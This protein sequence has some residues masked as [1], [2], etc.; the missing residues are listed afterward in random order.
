[1]AYLFE[2]LTVRG[3][4]LRNRLGVSPM[5]QYSSVDGLANEW[6]FVHLGARAVGG[7]ALVHVEATAVSPEGRISLRD[8]GLWSDAHVEP[9]ARIARFVSSQGAVAAIQLAHAGRKAS[10]HPP[11]TATEGRA[12]HPAHGGVAAAASD[13]GVSDAD[14]GWT[15]VAP[16]A[17]PFDEGYRQ[18]R[19]LTVE[20]IGAVVRQFRDAAERARAAGF[21]WLELHAA[22]GYLLH[23]FLSPLANKRND[24][25]GGSFDDRVRIVIDIVRAVRR[26]WPERLPLAVRLSCSDWRDDGWTLED[27][28]ALARRLGAE[29]VDLIDCSSGGILPR[30][31]IPVG[32]GYQVPFAERIRAQAGIMTA[33]VGMIT[34]SAQCDEIVRNGRADL[35]YLARQLLRDPHFPMRAAVELHHEDVMPVPPQYRRAYAGLP[36]GTRS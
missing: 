16:S 24:D 1:M 2:P 27:S 3:L 12:P 15:P 10:T 32:A 5:C 28:I 9:L 23:E 6:H 8:L 34:E 20:E 4:Q 36:Q 35:V 7:A 14:G 26:V 17:V 30:V 33:A 25:Y 13:G 29:G 18:P 21:D 22:H 31:T 11:W 19:A